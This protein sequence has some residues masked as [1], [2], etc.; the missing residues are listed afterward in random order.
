MR[1]CL[2]V[3]QAITIFVLLTTTVSASP[4]PGDVTESS[5]VERNVVWQLLG[6]VALPVARFFGISPLEDYP[7]PPK[8]ISKREDLPSPPKPISTLDDYPTPPKP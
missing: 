7:A 8:P 3:V 4:R 1:F 2:R 5:S 6:K